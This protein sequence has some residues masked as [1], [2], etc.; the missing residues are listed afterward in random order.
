[1]GDT[2]IGSVMSGKEKTAAD[3]AAA[4]DNA[5]FPTAEKDFTQ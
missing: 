4:G 1:M 5:V 2:E 3:E